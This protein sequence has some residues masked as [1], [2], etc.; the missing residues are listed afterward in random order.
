M[1]LKSVLGL[2]GFDLTIHVAVTA[3]L[4]FWIGAVNQRNDAIVFSSMT[5]TTSLILLAVRRKL[6]LRKRGMAGLTTGEMAAERLGELEQRLAEL[7]VLHG[8]IAELEERVDFAERI[9]AQIT[10]ER[11]LPRGGS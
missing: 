1:S 3:I 8:R 6:A 10:E 7:E 5:A 9:V 4:L 2:D 11:L